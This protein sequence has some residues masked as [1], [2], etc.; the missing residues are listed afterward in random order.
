[1]TMCGRRSPLELT[2]PCQPNQ[3]IYFGKYRRTVP[4]TQFMFRPFCEVARFSQPASPMNRCKRGSK[5]N[6]LDIH[7]ALTYLITESCAESNFVGHLSG[8]LEVKSRTPSYLATS[9]QTMRFKVLWAPLRSAR[10]FRSTSHCSVRP[11]P[12][13]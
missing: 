3:R 11:K 5:P 6:W 12:P 8:R 13:T 7:R 10:A 2:P 4:T 9:F 1:M